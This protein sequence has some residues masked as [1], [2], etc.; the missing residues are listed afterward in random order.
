MSDSDRRMRLLEMAKGDLELAIKMDD[1]VRSG[2]PGMGVVT[3]VFG[4]KPIE[5]VER[6][7]D[8]LEVPVFLRRGAPL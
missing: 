6:V 3:A 8:C 1:W 2:A 5:K 4:Y 7:V